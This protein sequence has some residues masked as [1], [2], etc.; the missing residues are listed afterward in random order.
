[1]QEE[2]KT[3]REGERGESERERERETNIHTH[4]AAEVQEMRELEQQR[5]P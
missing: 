1:M 2:V 5:Q 4:Q 3:H